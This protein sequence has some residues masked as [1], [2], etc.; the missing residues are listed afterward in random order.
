MKRRKKNIPVY[1]YNDFN[2]FVY[3]QKNK[4]SKTLPK[5]EIY[6]K[7]YQNPEFKFERRDL[8]NYLE[9]YSKNSFDKLSPE[10]KKLFYSY[11]LD[12]PGDIRKLETI[13]HNAKTND[14]PLVYKLI[15]IMQRE[16]FSDIK[17]FLEYLDRKWK[18]IR[19]EE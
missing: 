4:A 3:L 5:T 13:I 10:T 17:S 8:K 2:D 16:G 15:R 18:K 9:L 11:S 12:H 6:G 14:N 7:R 1:V 19:K